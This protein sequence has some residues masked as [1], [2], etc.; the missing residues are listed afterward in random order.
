MEE[1]ARPEEGL[2]LEEDLIP[3][4]RGSA[5]SRGR[6]DSSPEDMYG[7]RMDHSAMKHGLDL[8]PEEEGS[9][10]EEDANEESRLSMHGR[11]EGRDSLLKKKMQ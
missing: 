3:P 10:D 7:S 11:Q 8:L 1:E 2:I 9:E 4:Q 6:R 5:A